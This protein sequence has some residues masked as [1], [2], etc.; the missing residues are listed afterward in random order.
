MILKI[1]PWTKGDSF[2]IMNELTLVS[3][4]AASEAVVEETVGLLL[5]RLVSHSRIGHV[6]SYQ[7]VTVD[8]HDAPVNEVAM[9]KMTK[10][11]KTDQSPVSTRTL[12]QQYLAMAVALSLAV[13]LGALVVTEVDG[14]EMLTS[15]YLL[16][17]GPLFSSLLL[18]RFSL[19]P[20]WLTWYLTPLRLTTWA[21]ALATGTAR[22]KL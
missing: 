1:L 14:R 5:I 4:R 21:V 20:F 22:V 15:L 13:L 3:A 8:K 2:G 18:S 10:E 11:V 7:L 19:L 16:S 9:N 6:L 17:L 12:K